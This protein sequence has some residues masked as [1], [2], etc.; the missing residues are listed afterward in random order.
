LKNKVITL[1]LSDA[2]IQSGHSGKALARRASRHQIKL[3]WAQPE[4]LHYGAPRELPD[5]LLPDENFF[6]VGAI[7]FDRKGIDFDGANNAK[8]GLLQAQCEPTAAGKK[9]Y[10][11]GF[12]HARK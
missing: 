2:T 12:F 7:G 3:T 9:I 8:A 4:L 11:L 6:V 10:R 5:V 1:I